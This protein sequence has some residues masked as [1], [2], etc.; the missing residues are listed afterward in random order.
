MAILTY[1][2]IPRWTG[3]F[4]IPGAV[5]NGTTLSAIDFYINEVGSICLLSNTTIN[6][7]EY[8]NFSGI[9]YKAYD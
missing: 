9:Y 3:K 6:K 4:A 8:I 2:P 1:Y 7:N 5:D